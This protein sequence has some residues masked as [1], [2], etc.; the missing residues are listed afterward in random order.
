MFLSD[1]RELTSEVSHVVVAEYEVIVRAVTDV[2]VDRH[3]VD[4]LKSN[5]DTDAGIAEPDEVRH[6]IRFRCVIYRFQWLPAVQIFQENIRRRLDT[7]SYARSK[8]T[9]YIFGNMLHPY[10]QYIFNR[11]G[12]RATC[13]EQCVY[14]LGIAGSVIIPRGYLFD[15]RPGALEKV[16]MV[17]NTKFNTYFYDA[18]KSTNGVLDQ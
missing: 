18:A 15:F 9:A 2:L 7:Q 8:R 11:R 1:D 17:K 5:V 12:R 6:L 3:D 16:K 10:C 13:A 14:A 4:I